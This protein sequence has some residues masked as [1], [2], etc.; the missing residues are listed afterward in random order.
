MKIWPYENLYYK[1]KNGSPYLIGSKCKNCNHVSFPKRNVCPVCVSRDSMEDV[2][3][4]N[5]GKIETFSIM[6][7]GAPGFQVPY[8]V[9]YVK[10]PEGPKIFTIIQHEKGKEG[11]IEIGREVELTLGKI[12]E[13]EE[14]NEVIGFQFR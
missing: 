3:L 1:N 9:G 13:D 12:R 8:I 10:I 2:E 6:H 11:S 4:S 14:G 5:V 7:V